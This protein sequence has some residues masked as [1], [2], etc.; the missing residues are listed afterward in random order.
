M[1]TAAWPSQADGMLVIHGVLEIPKE[2]AEKQEVRTLS[3]VT[4]P[5]LVSH[6]P[7]VEVV[8]CSCVLRDEMATEV[9]QASSTESGCSKM[10][11][12][13]GRHTLGVHRAV[14]PLGVVGSMC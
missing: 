4:P 9:S 6:R 2:A 11:Q 8:M 10:R 3:M 1:G 5:C 12:L 13:M 14:P 7:L